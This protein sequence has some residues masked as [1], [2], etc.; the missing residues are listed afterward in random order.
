MRKKFVKSFGVVNVKKIR[1]LDRGSKCE[2]IRQID[3]GSKCEKNSV[4]SIGVVNVNT[5]SRNFWTYEALHF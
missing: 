4:K 1:Q 2:K 3:W 5:V